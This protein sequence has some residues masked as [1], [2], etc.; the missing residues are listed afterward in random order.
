MPRI[1]S[2]RV[3]RAFPELDR[4][5][6]AQCAAF[7][8]SAIRRSRGS[9]VIV[10]IGASIV[11]VCLAG[12]AFVLVGELLSLNSG[13][14]S[15]AR[16]FARNPGIEQA[17]LVASLMIP[18]FCG[19]IPALMIRDVWLRSAIRRRLG[20]TACAGCGYSMLG[21]RVADGSIQCPECGTVYVLADLG[22]SPADFLA[23]EPADPAETNRS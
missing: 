4:F 23:R 13:D 10:A 15:L 12:I 8:S 2:V 7:V 19:V 21:I 5:S 22:M 1:P 14:G 6:D 9:M 3:Y 18:V 20:S 11:C 16:W 17:M